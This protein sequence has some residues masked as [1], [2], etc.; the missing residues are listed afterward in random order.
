[1]NFSISFH[2]AIVSIQSG[3]LTLW[4]DD[5]IMSDHTLAS[6]YTFFTMLPHF[7]A[8]AT[9]VYH[10]LRRVSCINRRMEAAS[11]AFSSLF[12][13]SPESDGMESLPDRLENSYAYRSI[14]TMN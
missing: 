8:L 4:Y 6:A 12:R 1:M 11:E 2:A 10:C 14:S 13:R 5:Y 3:I 9:L 7:L